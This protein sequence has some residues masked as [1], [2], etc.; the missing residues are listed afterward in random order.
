MR[1]LFLSDLYPPASLGGYEVAAS[2]V[3]EAL[4]SRGH[5]V[6]VLTTDA[7]GG[8]HIAPEPR[9]RRSLRSRRGTEPSFL[10]LSDEARRQRDDRAAIDGLLAEA[11]PEVVFLWNIGGVSHQVL[12]RLMNRPLPTVIYVFGD[13]PLRKFLMP[14][15]LDPWAGVFAPRPE[16][17]W[18]RAAR[19]AFAAAARLQGVATEAAPLRFDHLEYGSRFMMNLLHRS[20]FQ[21]RGSERVIYYGLF[22]EFARAA[23]EPPAPRDPVSRELLFVGRIWEAKGLHTLVEAL[24]ILRGR[25]ESPPRLTIAGPEE[26]REYAAQLRARCEALG[27]ANRIRWAGALPRDALLPLYEKHGI[28]V[29]PSVY[30]EPFGIVQLEAMAAGCAVVGTATGGSAEILERDRNALVFKPDDAV[31]LAAHLSRLF[32]D[33]ALVQRLRLAGKETVRSRFLGTRMVDEI[34]E[35]LGAIVR[36][37]A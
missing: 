35:H 21:T 29:F 4:R 37:A 24:G 26:H 22:G 5:D 15:D 28:L 13:W 27:L 8:A 11:R 3:A 31:D 25:G 18:R 6:W 10:R 33:P 17:A 32:A 14:S 16:P 19:A 9:V 23:A 36:G 20:G 2:E 30:A 7:L 12:V 34:E 1:I